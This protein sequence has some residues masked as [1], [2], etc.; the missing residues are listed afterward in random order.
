MAEGNFLQAAESLVH[1]CSKVLL[2][3]PGGRIAFG[4]DR[5][6]S[7][8][9]LEAWLEADGTGRDD[10]VLTHVYRTR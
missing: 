10:V 3:C 1:R 4:A 9:G 2:V 8:G 6:R 7:L 5:N